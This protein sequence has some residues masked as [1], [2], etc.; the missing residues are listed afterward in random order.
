M[1]PSSSF[2]LAVGLLS[3]WLVERIVKGDGAMM[4]IG[5]DGYQFIQF[6]DIVIRHIR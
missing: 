6:F 5:C 1:I 2:V 3:C 4:N